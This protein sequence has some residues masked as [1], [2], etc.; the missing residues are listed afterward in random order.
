MRLCD[1]AKC[2][3]SNKSIQQLRH[4]VFKK[5]S[6][7]SVS[8]D[9]SYARRND[10]RRDDGTERNTDKVIEAVGYIGMHIINSIELIS[11]TNRKEDNS[12]KRVASGNCDHWKRWLHNS[13][14]SANYQQNDCEYLQKNRFRYSVVCMYIPPIFICTLSYLVFT[15]SPTPSI[16]ILTDF[17]RQ[18]S[19]TFC[20]QINNQSE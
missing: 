2:T 3:Q 12:Q 7:A 16:A 10:Q 1:D 8:F 20:L 9:V 13:N 5:G 6:F 14:W 17:A 19:N 15:S 18:K 4:T 11:R